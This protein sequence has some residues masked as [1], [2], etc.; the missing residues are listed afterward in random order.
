[1]LKARRTS[2]LRVR[3]LLCLLPRLDRN[4]IRRRPVM[5]TP[6]LRIKLDPVHA[7]SSG[8]ALVCQRANSAILKLKVHGEW[9]HGGNV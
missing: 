3:E 4:N 1:M 6:R 7:F 5:H 2:T 8:P 9:R